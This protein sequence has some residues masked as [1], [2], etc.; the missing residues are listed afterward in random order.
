[1]HTQQHL[2]RSLMILLLPVLIFATPST[3]SDRDNALAVFYVLDGNVEKAYNTLV[4][5]ELKKI[6]FVMADP[7]HRVNDQYEAKYGSTTLDVLSFLPAV[8]DDLVMKLFNTDPRLAGFSPFNMLIYKKKSDKVTHVGHLMPKAM[9]DMLGITD[10]SVR[11][12]FIASFDKLDAFVESYF[13][14]NGLKYKTEYI[15][16]K[17]VTKQKMITFE[18][19]FERP[20]ELDEFIEEFQ[21][22][23]E[24]AFIAKHYL[25]AGFHNFMDTDNGEDYLKDFDAFWSYSLCHL[26]YSYNVFDTKGARPDA[27]LFAPCT[28]YV[29][30]K[31]DSNKM[32]LGMPSLANVKN[33]LHI[34]SAKRVGWMDK[35]DREIPQILTDMG[36]QAVT[37]VNPLKETP[38]PI[39]IDMTPYGSVP[40]TVFSKEEQTAMNE[41][42]PQKAVT[43]TKNA[44]KSSPQPAVTS[45]TPAKAKTQTIENGGNT[46]N[47]VIPVPPKVP[48]P[49]KVHTENGGLTN[50]RGIQFS[51]RVPPGYIPPEERTA[52]AKPANTTTKIGEIDKG[53]I[54]TYLR[55]P[56]MDVAKAKKKLEQAGF[57]ILAVAPLGKKKELTTIV[58]TN[59]ALEKFAV[60]NNAEFLASLRLL[61][62]KKDN[63]ISITNP[64]YM[65]RAFI[66]K[67][68]FDTKVPKA[69]LA[70]IKKSFKGLVN[71]KDKLKYN[72]LPN[73]RFMNGMPQYKDMV[74][75]AMGSDLYQNIHGKKQV[76]FE[77]KL[78][79]GAILFGMKFRKRTQKFPYRIGTN[80]AALLPYPVLIKGDKAYIM[81]PKYYISV[82]YPLLKMSEFMTIATVPDAIL[83]ESQR[84]FRKKK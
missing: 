9:L 27:G 41:Q 39:K 43:K 4:E 25:I 8:N 48:T 66:Q 68:D 64:L 3:N 45:K 42:A 15:P 6:G 75:V 33:T 77:Q 70:K 83:K 57:K 69:L 37:N 31:K 38:K 23:F 32:Y 26:T 7:H 84:V 18:Y 60:D 17:N 56:Y 16:Y 52:K 65:A 2:L 59:D 35:L 61:I 34:T 46:V 29:F 5:K 49:V 67:D 55:A 78:P 63:H 14:S 82:M 58:F 22:K 71:S 74:E 44:A 20:E 13:K 36:M 79:N 12:P 24:L 50:L 1:M 81:D 54:S 76:V 21:N 28:M 53:R 19:T 10:E 73:Y 72:L 47:I 40:G 11:K 51:K 30:I 80:N 62:D